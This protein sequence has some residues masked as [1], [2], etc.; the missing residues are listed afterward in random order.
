[1]KLYRVEAEDYWF[2][3]LI[4]LFVGSV[5]IGLIGY[6]NFH[7]PV[8]SIKGG[9]CFKRNSTSRTDA[10]Y[11]SGFSYEVP[12]PENIPSENSFKVEYNGN[13]YTIK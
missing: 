9:P 11:F 8:D 10:K 13:V 7:A 12:R 4:W 1:M 2:W 3:F 5:I 6:A